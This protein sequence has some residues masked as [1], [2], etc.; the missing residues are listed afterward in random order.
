L[1]F[2]EACRQPSV[3]CQVLLPFPEPEFIALSAR[4]GEGMDAWIAWLAAQEPRVAPARYEEAGG[5]THV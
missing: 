2:L 4:T 5:R 3:R 1:L